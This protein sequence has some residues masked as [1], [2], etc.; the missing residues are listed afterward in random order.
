[1]R[2]LPR[3]AATSVVGPAGAGRPLCR[4]L[5]AYGAR[6]DAGRD[7]D[8]GAWYRCDHG[9][10]QRGRGDAAASAAISTGGP[11][12]QRRR[13]PSWRR[14]V[15]C[16]PV[17]AGMARPR[18]VGYLRPR[19]AGV[20]RRKQSDRRVAAGPGAA[21]ERHAELLRRA[22]RRAATWSHVP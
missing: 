1:D 9:D 6:A 11:S 13:R 20:V 3:I 12:R 17:A 22:R 15:R 18:A 4:P 16:R 7:G 2:T 10:V 14:V 8:N 21:D 5:L 19:R